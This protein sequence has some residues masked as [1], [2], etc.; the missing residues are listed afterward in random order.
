MLATARKPFTPNAVFIPTKDGKEGRDFDRTDCTLLHVDGE[1]TYGEVYTEE[2]WQNDGEPSYIQRRGDFFLPDDTEITDW[3]ECN[4]CPIRASSRYRTVSIGAMTFRLMTKRIFAVYALDRR[5][6]FH[7][8]ELCAS[9]ELRF[10][11]HQYEADR[12]GGPG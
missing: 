8:C 11:E 6:H 2:A 5:Q 7:L 4:C 12:R 1:Y 9:Y 10:I 3:T